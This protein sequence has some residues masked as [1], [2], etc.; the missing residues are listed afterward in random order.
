MVLQN[1][2]NLIEMTSNMIYIVAFG[3][4][5]K[6]PRKI[7]L[8]TQCPPQK[9]IKRGILFNLSYFKKWCCWAPTKAAIFNCALFGQIFC[10]FYWRFHPFHCQKSGQIGS[11]GRNHDQSKEPPHASNHPCRHSPEIS[12]LKFIIDSCFWS[13]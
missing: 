4:G 6:C 11:I 1:Y 12:Q 9:K 7:H 10:R 13:S 3:G 8:N 5:L 2:Q